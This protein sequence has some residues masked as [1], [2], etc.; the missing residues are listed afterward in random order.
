MTVLLQLPQ[1]KGKRP[2]RVSRV[3][4]VPSDAKP[5]ETSPRTGLLSDVHRSHSAIELAPGVASNYEAAAS[6]FCR[7]LRF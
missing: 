1:D 3:G 2:Q 6:T 7:R 5:V 4:A